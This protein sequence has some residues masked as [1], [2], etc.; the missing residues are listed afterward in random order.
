M[1]NGRPKGVAKRVFRWTAGLL[2]GLCLYAGLTYLLV[3]LAWTHLGKRRKVERL[4]KTTYTREGFP[5][6]PVNL[7]LLGD[8][9]AVVRAFAAAGWV[10]A[11]KTT[12]RTVA[13]AMKAF[14]LKKDYPTAP[15]SRLYYAGR[16]Q[17]LAFQKQVGRGN[18]RRH[19]VRLWLSEGPTEEGLP[20]WVGA[21]TYD[22]AV[23][24]ERRTGRLTHRIAPDIDAERE[25]IVAELRGASAVAGEEFI[26]GTPRRGRNGGGDRY[27]T[28][29]GL[30]VLTLR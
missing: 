18:R 1:M 17:D 28:D 21:A 27:H 3:P 5:G 9:E 25:L 11:D 7:A 16:R 4:S 22:A 19:H 6:D 29:G 15:V 24:F 23:K 14:V 30:K 13:K 8:R 2:A 12:P 10:P 20:L 26:P